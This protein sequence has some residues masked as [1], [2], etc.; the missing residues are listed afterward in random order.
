MGAVGAVKNR[1]SLIGI[2]NFKIVYPSWQAVEFAGHL[3]MQ[4]SKAAQ[5]IPKYLP[6]YLVCTCSMIDKFL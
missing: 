4:E 1:S 6:L 5:A 2:G 3:G